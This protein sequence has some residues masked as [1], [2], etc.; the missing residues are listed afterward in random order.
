MACA[1]PVAA[2]MAMAI[3][4]SLPMSLCIG[5]QIRKAGKRL[6]K[7]AFVA[8]RARSSRPWHCRRGG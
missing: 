3:A 5:A 4:M 8:G 6:L 2:Q 1:D 7:L